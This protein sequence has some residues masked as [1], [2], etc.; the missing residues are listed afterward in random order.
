MQFKT[1]LK[2][3][4]ENREPYDG[5]LN[6]PEWNKKRSKILQRDKSCCSKCGKTSNL[7]VHHKYYLW[8]AEPWQYDD[9]ALITL[10]AG[11]HDNIH[12]NTS[13]P[14]KIFIDGVLT[15]FHFTPCSRCGGSGYLNEYKHVQG[16][17][18]FR[19][20]G[21]QYEEIIEQRNAFRTTKVTFISFEN[22]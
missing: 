7:Q 6:S 19:C 5:L 14:W 18:C 11:C 22:E 12:K 9:D 16:G 3:I 4:K 15:D 8:N 10:C 1:I 21:D 2:L 20:R 13:M 17:I